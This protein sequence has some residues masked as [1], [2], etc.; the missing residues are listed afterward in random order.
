[1]DSWI[2]YRFVYCQRKVSDIMPKEECEKWLGFNYFMLSGSNIGEDGYFYNDKT[3]M[4]YKVSK[5]WTDK[6]FTNI[7]L[8]D[9]HF[10]IKKISNE[11]DY[12]LIKFKTKNRTKK[13]LKDIESI[14]NHL[15]MFKGNN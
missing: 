9:G 10:K 14:Y 13:I 6:Y 5:K 7:Q 2:Q 4:T 1:M 12:C 11:Y 15:E 8:V 3:Q